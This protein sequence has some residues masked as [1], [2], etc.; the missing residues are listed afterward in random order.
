MRVRRLSGGGERSG[1]APAL[2][3]LG[4]AGTAAPMSLLPFL[5][6]IFGTIGIFVVTFALQNIV[7]VEDGIPPGIDSI[8]TCVDGDRLTAHWPDGGAGP[9]AAP[10]RSLEL[11]QAL[12]RDG[13]PFRNLVLALGGN[14]L[15]ARLAFL[16]GF[17]RYLDVST[18]AAAA[19]GRAPTG[20]M[21][22]LYP[23]GD[24]ADAAALLDEWRKGGVR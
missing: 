9:V 24:E 19:D 15:E 12:A 8:V 21:L 2:A 1:H 23:L 3:R 16:K 22:E 10:E 6:I 11:L 13:R 18:R 17:E 5:D 14:C 7:E 20:L 4:G